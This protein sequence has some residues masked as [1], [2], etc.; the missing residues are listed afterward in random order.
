MGQH[1]DEPHGDSLN[2][3]L[4]WLRA[5]V[6]G[7]NDGIVSV[8]GI[9]M[10]FAGATTDRHIDLRRRHGRPGRRRAEHGGRGVRLGEHP[11]RH[12]AGADR[13]GAP[14]AGG[15]ARGGAGRAGR[16]LP[17]QGALPRSSPARSPSSSPRRTRCAPTSRSSSASTP[18]SSPARGRPRWPRCCPSPSAPLLPLLTILLF[19][20]DLRGHRDR[21]RVTL[22]L[23]AAPA[24]VRARVGER[25][26]GPA[27]LRNVVG[28]LLAMGVTYGIGAWSGSA[29]A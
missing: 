19:P 3:L 14:R 2:G 29:L 5:A 24:V 25:R 9:V 1:A 17:R 16:P 15:G 6:L 12:R 4:N 21:G 18:T 27:V 20:H 7:A 26:L 28:G 22:A 13:Q 8:A 11:A 10:G 23:G